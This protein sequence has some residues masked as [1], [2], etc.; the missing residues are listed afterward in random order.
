[1]PQEHAWLT[2]EQIVCPLYGISLFLPTIIKSLNYT[3]TQAQLMTVPI[4][5]TAAILAVIVAFC[6]D[7]VGKRSPFVIGPMLIMLV[8]FTM[9]V[10][11]CPSLSIHTPLPKEHAR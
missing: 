4:Y 1:L 11:L 2:T 7:K 9:Y 8:G 5:I 10:H 6:S 3:K